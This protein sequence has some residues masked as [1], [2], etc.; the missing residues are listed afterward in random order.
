MSVDRIC[1][2]EDDDAT[3]ESVRELLEEEG[4][5]V[6]E[7]SNGPE[8][9]ALLLNRDE[10]MVVILDQKLPSLDGC[11]LLAIVAHDERLRARHSFVFM[12]A[13][14]TIVEED[15]DEVIED[16]DADVLPKP[17]SID[18]MVEAVRQAVLRL[19]S[20]PGGDGES[21]PTARA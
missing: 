9:L 1:I 11:D 14:P 7:A 8:G 16:L 5:T 2:I 20:M 15:C 12:T 19:E 18:E 3:R 10:R 21:T 4:Y 6:I 13:S 17:F